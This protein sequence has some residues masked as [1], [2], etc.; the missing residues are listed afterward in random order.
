LI[1]GN[2]DTNEARAEALLICSAMLLWIN[3][4]VTFNS[5]FFAL[6]IMALFA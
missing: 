5:R 4:D 6:S 2:E 1:D 3:V